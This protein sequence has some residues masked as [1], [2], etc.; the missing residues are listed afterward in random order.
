MNKQKTV[1]TRE[2]SESKILL[3]VRV[4]SR[5]ENQSANVEIPGEI[6]HERVLATMPILPRNF[7]IRL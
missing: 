1:R 7:Q 5:H 6:S 3:A 4:E 2:E